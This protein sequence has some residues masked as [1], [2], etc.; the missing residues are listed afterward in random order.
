MLV[1][2]LN[3]G[4]VT[5]N[6]TLCSLTYPIS[7]TVYAGD[8]IQTDSKAKEL[9]CGSLRYRYVPLMNRTVC[10]SH[11][12]SFWT[13]WAGSSRD[14]GSVCSPGGCGWA[15]DVVSRVVAALEQR[16]SAGWCCGNVRHAQRRHACS[17]LTR[18]K[19][20]GPERANRVTERKVLQS[21]V[22]VWINPSALIRQRS[23]SST[24]WKDRLNVILSVCSICALIGW[25]QHQ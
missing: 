22:N 19:L 10:Y 12:E 20:N 1:Y 5:G 9:I 2:I 3:S 24:A 14:G 23:H 16:T 11:T 13:R 4:Y 8:V 15:V 21:F 25:L 18:R 17:D 7:S 6:V